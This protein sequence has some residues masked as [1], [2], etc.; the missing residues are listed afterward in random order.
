MRRFA[1]GSETYDPI[2]LCAPSSRPSHCE[3][4]YRTRKLSLLE[5]PGRTTKRHR[6]G[7]GAEMANVLVYLIDSTDEMRLELARHEFSILLDEHKEFLAK[8]IL[9]L[10]TKAEAL[11]EPEMK[12]LSERLDTSAWRTLPL[13][14]GNAAQVKA[15]MDYCA[16]LQRD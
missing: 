10:F 5:M 11:G 1:N 15:V 8:R 2:P 13:S 3:M 9:I 6:W 4:I 7:A 16:G 14:L 12:D